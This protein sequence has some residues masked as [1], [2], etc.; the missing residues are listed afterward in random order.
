MLTLNLSAGEHKSE[1]F[2]KIN[3]RSIVPTIVVKNNFVLWESK[4]ILMYLPDAFGK[5]AFYPM[6][7]KTRAIIN[8]RLLFDSVDFYPHVTAVTNLAYSSEA[9]ITPK[10]KINLEKALSVMESFLNG[11]DF[12]AGKHVTMADF[13]F[14]SSIATLIAIGFNIE[15]YQNIFAWFERMKSFKGFDEVEQGAQEYG[16]FVKEKLQNSFEDL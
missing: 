6:C 14:C 3:P 7:P 11:H 4:A 16:K 8:Q 15:N 10:H 1:E 13:A 2:V 12:F 5:S 9:I